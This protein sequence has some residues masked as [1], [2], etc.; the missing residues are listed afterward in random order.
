[1]EFHDYYKVLG[2]A[3]DCSDKDIKRAYRKL[4]REY[5]PDISKEEKA[6]ER[7]KELNEA[8]EVLKD[9]EKRKRYDALG[10]NWKAGED[11]Q[12]PPNWEDIYGGL[13]SGGHSFRFNFNED[14]AGGGFSDFFSM[15]F[16]ADL[17]GMQSQTL[18]DRPG[19][20]VEAEL[21]ISLEEAFHGASKS[22]TLTSLEPD[23]HGQLKQKQRAYQVKVPAGTT[24]GKI[25]RLAGQ[26]E[27]GVGEGP[28]GDLFLHV[29]LSSHPRFRVKRHNLLGT[30]NISP[31]E[32]A[33]GGKFPFQTLDG[34]V[35]VTVPRGTQSGQQ[36][37][38]KGK[39]LPK[40]EGQ[41]GDLLLELKVVTPSK[42]TEE[43]ERIFRNLSETSKF[44]PRM[45]GA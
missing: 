6:E 33:L 11:F 36:L 20:A 12:P 2:V 26:G 19:R 41:R 14:T 38:L 21:T 24:A 23:A 4:A 5:H 42:L 15:L 22:L 18:R 27:K 31:W 29:K 17:E 45:H 16:G 9:P 37:R 7:F 10:P 1:M 30:L 35:S 3:R 8:Y 43:E 13:G 32:A 25:I 44:D 28:A 40:R 34:R 39:G